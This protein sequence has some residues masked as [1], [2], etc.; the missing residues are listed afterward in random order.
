[1]A[2]IQVSAP[3][4]AAGP[5]AAP[6]APYPIQRY[7][8]IFGAVAGLIA[9]VQVG[10]SV[11]SALENRYTLT[12]LYFSAGGGDAA[13]VS[14]LLAAMPLLIAAY[15]TALAGFIFTLILCWHAGRAAA[16]ETGRAT[17]GTEA[18]LLVGTTGALI[19][20]IVSVLAV[21]LFHTEGSLAGIA[22]ASA[23]LSPA[24]DAREIALLVSQ[25]T[26]AILFGLGAFALVG[27]LA[28]GSAVTALRRAAGAPLPAPSSFSPAPWSPRADAAPPPSGHL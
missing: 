10:V 9:I 2:Y 3:M 1:M 26:V 22:T 15:G 16:L 24:T 13:Q 6:P 20:V 27:W 8:L 12:N 25:E 18:G 11:V 28:G 17:A 14:A 7:G 19:W 4:G 23:R 5:V 21:L